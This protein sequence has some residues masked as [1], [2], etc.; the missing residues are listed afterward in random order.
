MLLVR[1]RIG[2]S[3]IHGLGVFAEEL[4]SRG[5]RV[6]EFKESVDQVFSIDEMSGLPEPAQSTIRNLA[7][8]CKDS[9]H[10]VL[11]TDGAQFMNHSSKPNTGVEH[12]E[13]LEG[14]NIALQDIQQG[15]ELTNDYFDYDL[16]AGKKLSN[17]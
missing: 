8:L 7:Y 14:A 12:G 5:T 16:E 11:A 1:T 9:Q 10:Y 2:L 6:W 15:E 3:N 13:G 4:I 17:V